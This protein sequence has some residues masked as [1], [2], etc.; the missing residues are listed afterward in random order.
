MFQIGGSESDAVRALYKRQLALD[1]QI[2]KRTLQK[3]D[4]EIKK[5]ELEVEKLEYEKKVTTFVTIHFY[6]HNFR[7]SYCIQ[8]GLQ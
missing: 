7:A 1:I 6:F 8:T 3:V 4:L 5:L 2:K